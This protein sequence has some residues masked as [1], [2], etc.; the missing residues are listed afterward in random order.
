MDKTVEAGLTSLLWKLTIGEGWYIILIY[1]NVG[2]EHM[3]RGKLPL[4]F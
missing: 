1:D 3:S 4:V 2:K